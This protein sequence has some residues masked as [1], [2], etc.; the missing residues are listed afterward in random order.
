M[1]REGREGLG[2]KAGLRLAGTRTRRGGGGLGGDGSGTGV[3]GTGV[4]GTVRLAKGSSSSRKW[5][6][7]ITYLAPKLNPC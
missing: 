2:A 1:S 3:V 7:T 4:V 6:I 5:T